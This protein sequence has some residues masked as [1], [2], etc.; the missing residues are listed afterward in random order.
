MADNL[1]KI[2]HIV[3][4]MMENRSFDH[5]LG[6]LKLMEGKSDVDGLTG[7]ESNTY[8]ST[9]YNVHP[10]LTTRF[11]PDPCHAWDCVHE[12]LKD[13]N[14][15]FVREFAKLDPHDPGRIMGFHTG[16]DLPV[17][18]H[19]AREYCICDRWFSSVPGPT[20]PNRLYAL[21]GTSNGLKDNPSVPPIPKYRMKTVF[22][23]LDEAKAEWRYYSHDIAFLR[24]FKKYRT[25]IKEI[26]KINSFYQRVAEGNL[27]AVCWIDP[28]FQ[29]VGSSGNDDHPPADVRNGQA[30]V[31][32]V[33]N[34][35]LNGA[36]GLWTK[37]LLVVT[38]DE[39]GGFYDHV[40]PG[41]AEDKRPDFRQYGVRVPAFVISP[42]VARGTVCHTTFDHA[43]VLRAILRKFCQK[44][45]GT[46]PSM[47]DR[48]D[49]AKEI[50]P[51]LAEPSPRT[52]CT[53][54]PVFE[55]SER[56]FVTLELPG[57]EAEVER[58]ETFRPTEKT[59]LQNLLSQLRDECVKE[60]VPEDRL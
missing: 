60:G 13:N 33:Y 48:V 15:G 1:E 27:P 10:L 38:Y 31:R 22:Q 41:P 58:E 19:L 39:H 42:W 30:L 46:V 57:M 7:R 9:T 8:N 14:G 34:A 54:A 44:K 35:L 28:N 59:E 37:T 32:A 4:V 20:W 49:N 16:A 45:D 6:Y 26:D 50:F 43:S 25:N 24:V 55:E 12:Q 18:N 53:E 5:M 11:E 47:T 56:Y 51:L 40:V 17:Y 29:D 36:N 2:D 23:Y 21:A 52:D 3:V